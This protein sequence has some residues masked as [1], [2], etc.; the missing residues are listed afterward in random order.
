M[1]RSPLRFAFFGSSLVSSYWNGA[2]TYYRGLLRALA[3]RGHTITF[4]E[5]D[6]FE[7]QAHRDIDDPSYARVVVYPGDDDDAAL[8]QVEH[9]AKT[10]DVLVKA[11]G[12]GV[13]DRL[14]ERAIV[15]ARRERQLAIFWDVDA[16]ATLARM[17]D[18]AGDPFRALVPRYDAIL[19]YGGGEPVVRAYREFGAR[20]CVPIY[21][22]LD[23]DTHHPV[24]PDPRYAA[25]LSLLANRLPDREARIFEYFFT[26][27]RR[28]P[29]RRFLLGG[30]GW[31]P[32]APEP[33][34]R[35]L[36]HVPTAEHNAFNVSALAVLKA[37]TAEQIARRA[38]LHY[39][40]WRGTP[41]G[42]WRARVEALLPDGL[43]RP[44]V[45][46]DLPDAPVYW[47][48]PEDEE[49]WDRAA[50][51]A[52][53]TVRLVPPLDNLLFSRARL[54]ALFG[55]DYKFEA[56]TPAAQRRF[57]FA[58]PVLYED[59]VAGL[60]DARLADGVWQIRGIELRRP[61]PSEALRAG[62]YR[63]AR[64]AGAEKVAVTTRT[65]REIRRALVGR[66]DG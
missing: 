62:V 39:G 24:V 32:A 63:V 1:K 38:R 30:N 48:R 52:G 26:P 50:R 43:A 40:Q 23:P 21:N 57:Y 51:A 46:T 20:L 2:A 49:G 14:L 65:T 9:A 42:H 64:L 5:P 4:Y 54:G 3:G 55:L 36:G 47:Y 44:V 33:N 22:A 60:I 19:T 59:A 45:V 25:D 7:R 28:L 27:A 29:G 37:G 16:P 18:D 31:G 53:P 56:Y 41:I 34:V 10:A 35:L 66:C 17:R 58:L 8:Q 15:E 6:A 11:S 13:Y 61:V 12:V